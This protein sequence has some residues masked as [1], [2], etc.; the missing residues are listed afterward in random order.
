[1]L[2]EGNIGGSTK[3]GANLVGIRLIL[4]SASSPAF[5]STSF[6]RAVQLLSNAEAW[7]TRLHQDYVFHMPL[8]LG[9]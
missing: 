5:P 4:E 9:A 2:L 1:M 8:P 7:N 3:E 6:P